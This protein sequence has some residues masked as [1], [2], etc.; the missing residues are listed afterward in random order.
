MRFYAFGNMYLSSIQ[1]GI[2]AGHVIGDMAVKYNGRAGWQDGQDEMYYDWAAEH[3][4]MILLNGGF[5][6]DLLEFNSFLEGDLD[7]DSERLN[8]HYD[9]YSPYPFALFS[10]EGIDD[11]ASSFGLVLP[12]EIY[13]GIKLM[14]KVKR[15]PRDS[16]DRQNW[17]RNKILKFESGSE[18]FYNDWEI[19]LMQRINRC[20]L[21]I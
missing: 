9:G 2:Q 11:A 10:E 5:S 21:A 6:Q 1:Q 8:E 17:E 14:N 19:E 7:S 4:T 12:P 16:Y 18:R 3:K 13:E 20:K 15:M